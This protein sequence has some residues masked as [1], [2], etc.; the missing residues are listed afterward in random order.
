[1]HQYSQSTQELIDKLVIANH[2]LFDQGVVDAFG[3][4]SVRHD[5]RDD[6]FFLAKNKAPGDIEREDILEFGLDGELANPNGERVYLERYLHSEIYKARPDVISIVHSHSHNIIPFS[7]LRNVPLRPLF[8]MAGFIHDCA[9][10]F[11]IRDRF[12]DTTNLLVS[13]VER[14]KAFAECIGDRPIAL[15][16]GHGS[17]VVADSLEKAVFRAVYAEINAQLQGTASPLG[18]VTFLTGDEADACMTTN[19]GQVKRPW[20]LWA[21]KARALRSER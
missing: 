11:E 20:D 3:H 6:R 9:P 4:V 14:G 10:V 5:E 17:T 19:E 16:R 1:M 13:D 15:M 7:V 18:D 2:I 12:G 21:K 8:H